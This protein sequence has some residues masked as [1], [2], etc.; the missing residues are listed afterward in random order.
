VPPSPPPPP[1]V[2]GTPA[3]SGLTLVN[4]ASDADIG[5]FTS[6][7]TI[8]L[9]DTPS[10]SVRANTTPA[11][12]GS[13]R[14]T[15]NGQVLR[16]ENTA[17]YTIAG[18]NGSDYLG[19]TPPVGT[20]TLVVTPFGGAN[21]TGTAGTPVT[22]NFTVVDTR[23]VPP[24]PSSTFTQVNWTAKKSSPIGRAEALK[25]TVD[26]KIY[27]FGGFS[28]AEGPV[29]RSDVYDP[30]A[31]TWTRIADLPERTTHAGVAVVGRDVYI[32]GGYVGKPDKVG[33][34]QF[35]GT[36]NVWKYNVDSNTYTAA[37]PLPSAL[38]G[39]G[40]V[41]LNGKLHYF[42]GYRLDRSDTAEHWV[43]DLANTGAGWKSA[44]AMPQPRNHMGFVAFG[45]KI[46]AIAGQIKSDAQLVTQNDVFI[47]DPAT[48]DWT[49][50]ADMPFSAGHISSATFVMGDRIIVAGGETSSGVKTNKVAAY[51]P[52][53]NSWV[54]LSNLPQAR[55][56]GVADVVNGKIIYTTGGS[57][58]TWSG[59]P[60]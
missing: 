34:D 43:L 58:L 1:P 57:D 13:V 8:D 28:G 51:T 25:G 17:P 41:H 11:V 24:P 36:V 7:A 16:T 45:G 30:A 59:T 18:D 44:K 26:G 52:A 20:H 9:K 48:N 42:G 14:F 33:Y 19:W 37:T 29:R 49:Q 31:D 21:G 5:A 38:A 2:G 3:L 47:Y 12:I 53:T 55:F 23:P 56:S 60:A 46:Y 22:V 40:L 10:L 32:A 35:F 54:L 15:L 27:V 4:A 50:G 6:G 39:G